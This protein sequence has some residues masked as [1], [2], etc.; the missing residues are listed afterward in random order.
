MHLLR[1]QADIN[2]PRL[3]GSGAMIQK[4]GQKGVKAEEQVSG[5][6]WGQ[7]ALAGSAAVK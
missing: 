7:N 6:G 3:F 5:A 4:L 1:T 2:H